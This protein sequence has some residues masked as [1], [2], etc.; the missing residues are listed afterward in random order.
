MKMPSFQRFWV[1]FSRAARLDE[2]SPFLRR[3]IV[4][5]VGA[6]ILLVGLAMTVLPGPA[7]IVVPLGLAVL[8]TE[9]AWARRCVHKARQLFK[10][11][12]ESIAGK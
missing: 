12:K 10:G 2:L 8:A 9:F 11:A 7:F 5:V 6:T 4:G 1:R 3:L